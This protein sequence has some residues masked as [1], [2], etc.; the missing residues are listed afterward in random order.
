MIHE[1]EGMSG[2]PG[3]NKISEPMYKSLLV[4]Q[5]FEPDAK[6]MEDA[7]KAVAY[8]KY[9]KVTG[10]NVKTFDM[11]KSGDCDAFEKLILELYMKLQRKEIFLTCHER[12]FVPSLGTWLVHMEWYSFKLEQIKDKDTKDDNKG[13]TGR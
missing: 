4:T 8:D 9:V 1:Y 11:N 3:L 12:H 7:A 10:Y 5:G 2:T 13:S 6:D